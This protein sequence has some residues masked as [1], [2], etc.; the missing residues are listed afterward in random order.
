VNLL[1]WD[2]AT[3]L[4]LAACSSEIDKETSDMKHPLEPHR[5]PSVL[6]IL[7]KTP[8]I[9]I[10]MRD[11][12]LRTPL[13]HAIMRNHI[14]IID[15]LMNAGAKID[16]PDVQGATPV[17]YAYRFGQGKEMFQRFPL[18][19][20]SFKLKTLDNKTPLEMAVEYGHTDVVIEYLGR[21]DSPA[22][23]SLGLRV[24]IEAIRRR[25]EDIV[26]YLVP[27][28]KLDSYLLHMVCRQT[29][30]HELISNNIISHELI[31]KNTMNEI[32]TD[33]YTA[34]MIAVKYGQVECVDKLI[35]H[36][37]CDKDV[38]EKR[39]LDF[40]RTVLHICAEFKSYHI[41]DLLLQKAKK[42]AL[43]LAP[44]DVMGNT[45]LHV[46][47]QKDNQY[48]SD[49]LLSD[50]DMVVTVSS[51]PQGTSSRKTEN[52]DKISKMLK[53]KNNNG[54]TAF[55]EAIES[56]HNEIVLQMLKKVIDRVQLIE[57][58]DQQ[59]RTSLHMAAFKGN[60]VL[61]K[62]F[63]QY[64][65]NVHACDVNDHTPL[66][67]AARWSDSDEKENDHRNECIDLLIQKG[68]KINA[69]NIRRES[70]LHVACRYGSSSL[71][72]SLMKH[73]ADILLTNI[74][75]YN[76]L[77]GHY[78]PIIHT[79]DDDVTHY[80]FAV[81]DIINSQL[82]AQLYGFIILLDFTKCV[83][84]IDVKFI[85]IINSRTSDD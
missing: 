41:T 4:H 9:K 14:A 63:L 40:N 84:N 74:Q 53:I 5:K 65:V 48:M 1:G 52:E 78:D 34:L 70:P 13:H 21:T 28:T 76:C 42:I 26:S 47:V 79:I 32:N 45:P 15:E 37:Y 6:Q 49:R 51:I 60:S 55:H 17:H 36:Q 69:L 56:G 33:G 81:T 68:A 62:E 27:R 30:G 59:L 85:F 66:H 80:A 24:L 23:P 61:L 38:L 73:G 39:S 50:R 44:V 3:P 16:V 72:K 46:C 83:Q 18:D 58:P 64:E 7:L 10:N 57:E 82:I 54:L 19:S 22:N 29:H 35:N 12:Q 77:E 71:V 67:E 2:G 43:D 20:S 75:N 25:Q 8:K 31:T 11:N